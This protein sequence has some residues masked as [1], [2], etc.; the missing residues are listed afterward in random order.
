MRQGLSFHRVAEC[1]YRLHP[2]GT[3]YALVKRHG[4]QIKRSLK[5]TDRQLAERRLRDFQGKAETLQCGKGRVAFGVLVEEYRQTVL[6]AKDL[7][8]ASLLETEQRLKT[9]LRKW[10][11]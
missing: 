2:S 6:A 10:P 1:L 8:P 7:K 3:Y 11:V 4:K 9:V 5:T